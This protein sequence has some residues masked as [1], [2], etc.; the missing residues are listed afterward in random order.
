MVRRDAVAKGPGMDHPLRV[1]LGRGINVAAPGSVDHQLH[2][3]HPL[4][5]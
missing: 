5:R 3:G 4:R 2:R 1:K